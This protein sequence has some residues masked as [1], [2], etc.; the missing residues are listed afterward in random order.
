MTFAPDDK[1]LDQLS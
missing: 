1:K